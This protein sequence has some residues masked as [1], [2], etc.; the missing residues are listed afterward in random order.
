MK[1]TDIFSQRIFASNSSID[2]SLKPE[3]KERLSFYNDVLPFNYERLFDSGKLRALLK[4]PKKVTPPIGIVFR[5]HRDGSAHEGL[6][7]MKGA[8]YVLPLIFF[9]NALIARLVK[10][11][12]ETEVSIWPSIRGDV[13]T[14]FDE[15]DTYINELTS[16]YTLH[17]DLVRGYYKR[18][19]EKLP[20]EECQKLL[21]EIE[22]LSFTVAFL[23]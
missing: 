20:E 8:D 6:V 2:D 5:D 21:K 23:Q 7:L 18:E 11:A 22:N 10:D 1:A 16:I 3:T 14:E 4:E 9:H 19:V 12:K 17:F 13:A 15:W